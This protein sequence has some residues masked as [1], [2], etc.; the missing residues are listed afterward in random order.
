MSVATGAAW[1]ALGSDTGGSIRIPA[2]LQGLVGFKNTARLTPT[3]GAIPLSTTLDTVCA[4]THSVRDAVLLHE[5]HR[6]APGG[7]RRAAAGRHFA[8][9]YPSS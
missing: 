7:A 8:S 6:R 2:A 1:A 5:H 4:I 3:D 9:A